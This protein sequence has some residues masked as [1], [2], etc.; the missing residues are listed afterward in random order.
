MAVSSVV[1]TTLFEEGVFPPAPSDIPVQIRDIV[2]WEQKLV[3]QVEKDQQGA[4]AII[5]RYGL[6]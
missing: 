2:E 6:A 5:N 3:D 4:A 1:L